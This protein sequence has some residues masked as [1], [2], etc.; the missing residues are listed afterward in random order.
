MRIYVFAILAASAA[1]SQHP[2]FAAE[3]WQ[4]YVNA[5]FGY[6]LC[7][8]RPALRAGNEAPNGDGIA[9]DSK[10]GAQV[11]VYGSNDVDGDSFE[12]LVAKQYKEHVARGEQVTYR[13]TGENWA[14]LSGK[15]A[16]T[17]FYERFVVRD[18]QSI[19]LKIRYPQREKAVW[20]PIV[21]R[22]SRCLSIGT[23]AF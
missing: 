17:I 3:R 8:P 19:T 16:A 9:L 22:M 12:H 5:R 2:V 11:S 20:N 23:P 14:V 7:Y 21:S 18:D 10:S 6:S 13:R 4:T 1:I 15:N